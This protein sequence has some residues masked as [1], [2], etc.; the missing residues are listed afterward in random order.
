[1]LKGFEKALERKRW[2]SPP[3]P[4]LLNGEHEAHINA[5]R[6]GPPPKGYAAWSWRLLARTVVELGIV[7]SISHETIRRTLKERDDPAEKSRTG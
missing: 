2:E 7:A 1:M 5:L 4:K 6:L 3:V